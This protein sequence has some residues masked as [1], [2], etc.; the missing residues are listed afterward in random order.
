MATTYPSSCSACDGCPQGVT[1]RPA[2]AGPG[3]VG[4]PWCTYR[5][6]GHHLAMGL[7]SPGEPGVRS[8]GSTKRLGIA[9]SAASSGRP[10]AG[11]DLAGK[12]SDRNAGLVG[13][14]VQVGPGLG[15]GAVPSH[16]QDA[17]GLREDGSV[18]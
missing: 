13:G 9:N 2:C 18:V 8:P 5:P 11:D 7:A 10:D 17:G 12:V 4:S 1:A 6:V 3:G 15:A 16:H 14:A